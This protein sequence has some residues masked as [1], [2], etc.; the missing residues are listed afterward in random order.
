M[1]QTFL[2]LHPEI[3]AD[4]LRKDNKRMYRDT[5]MLILENGRLR[6]KNNELTSQVAS[7]REEVNRLRGVFVDSEA[8]K[9]RRPAGCRGDEGM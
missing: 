6:L 4:Q 2:S 1:F 5:N 9:R 7:L 3:N 8:N